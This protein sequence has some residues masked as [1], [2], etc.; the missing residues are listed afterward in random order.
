MGK[1]KVQVSAPAAVAM[2]SERAW[3]RLQRDGW[4]DGGT[5]ENR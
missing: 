3:I 1:A 5:R 4:L 2:L